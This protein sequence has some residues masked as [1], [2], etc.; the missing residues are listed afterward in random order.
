MK[1]IRHYSSGYPTFSDES[2]PAPSGNETLI[3]GFFLE[4]SESNLRW[5]SSCGIGLKL[6]TNI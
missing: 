5:S 6:F 1:R 3:R 2:I 4:T